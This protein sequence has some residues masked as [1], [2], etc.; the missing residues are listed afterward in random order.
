V[1]LSCFHEEL[2]RDRL[3][4]GTGVLAGGSN[5]GVLFPFRSW[6]YKSTT[7]GRRCGKR[8]CLEQ[9]A[10]LSKLHLHCSRTSEQISTHT[11][12]NIN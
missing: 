9:S 7:V 4:L 11:K 2:P 3:A 6:V 1:L 5:L 10:M 8:L 12:E